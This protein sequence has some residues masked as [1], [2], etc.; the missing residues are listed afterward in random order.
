[1]I[2]TGV[3]SQESGVRRKVR[4]KV[5]SQN[6]EFR[7]EFGNVRP[8]PACRFHPIIVLI[9]IAA[10]FWI[11]L[12]AQNRPPASDKLGEKFQQGVAD[13]KAGRLDEARAVFEELIRTGVTAPFVYH[14]LGIVYQRLRRHQDAV[15]QFR[16]ALKIDPTFAESR[17][18]LGAG[19]LV[20][21]RPEE[22]IEELERAVRALPDN[23]S[24]NLQL[25]QAYEVHGTP[26]QLA[27]QYN[28]LAKLE[29]ENPEY[30]YQLGEAY[31][32]VADWCYREMLSRDLNSVRVH[33]ALG[34]IYMARKDWIS[35]EVALKRAIQVDPKLPDLHMSLA[36]ALI[37]Q[38]KFKEALAAVEDEL[39][40]VPGNLGARRLREQLAAQLGP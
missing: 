22:A 29:P 18:L 32:A 4:R 31:S 33:Q 40:I 9:L 25:A 6:S 28:R 1:M 39:R 2:Q 36:A 26:F 17:V 20:L 30:A 13:L 11:P 7:R 34:Q 27:A 12:A 35:A 19:L 14:N 5:R 10:L 16:K 8:I 15:D 21:N 24:A 37:Q 3:R 23:I 38:K